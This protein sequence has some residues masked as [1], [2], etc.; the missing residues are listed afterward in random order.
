[1]G[2]GLGGCWNRVT[3]LSW[4]RLFKHIKF[5]LEIVPTILCDHV[6]TVGVVTKHEDKLFTRLRH[7]DVRQHWL[8]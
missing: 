6:Q 4:N 5:D 8:R 2:S 3:I 1:M 7:V